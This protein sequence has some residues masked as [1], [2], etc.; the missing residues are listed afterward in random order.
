MI[1]GP[2]LFKVVLDKTLKQPNKNAIN[3]TVTESQ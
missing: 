1:T 3:K 2:L